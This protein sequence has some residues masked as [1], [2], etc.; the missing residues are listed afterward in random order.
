MNAKPIFIVRTQLECSLEEINDVREKL[1][2][3]FTDY[4]VLVIRGLK[5]ITEFECYNSSDAD[6]KSLEELKN[7]VNNVKT[8]KIRRAD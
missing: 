3:S 4:H 5:N 1:T 6:E 2:K 8:T 7:I